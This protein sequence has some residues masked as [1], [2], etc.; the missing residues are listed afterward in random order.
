[1]LRRAHLVLGPLLAV[2]LAG[3]GKAPPPPIV[4]V[5]GQVLLD[6][7]PVNKA[8]VL[9][10]PLIPYGPEYVAK[11]VTDEQGRFQLTC[12][13][14]PGACACENQVVIRESE[15][16]DKLKGENAQAELAKYLKSLGGRPLPPRYANLVESPLTAKVTAEEITFVFELKR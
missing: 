7:E 14:Q 4:P 16:P 10:I 13:G 8:E 2:L 1:M 11:G 12:K 3:C 9:F 15:L 6:G 5:E